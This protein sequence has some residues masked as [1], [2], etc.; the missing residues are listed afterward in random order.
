VEHAAAPVEVGL[1]AG[2]VAVGGQDGSSWVQFEDAVELIVGE[3]ES[4]GGDGGITI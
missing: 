2:W 4:A 1:A 3:R